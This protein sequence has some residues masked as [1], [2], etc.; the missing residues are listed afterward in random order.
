M[1]LNE[2]LDR[3]AGFEAVPY[4]VVSLY[5]NTQ[6]NERGRDSFQ[7]FVRKELKARAQT[8]PAKSPERETLERDLERITRY[9]ETDVKP[10]ANGIAIF[11]CDAAGLFE[12]IQLDGPLEDHWLSIGDQPHLYPLARVASQFP[13]CAAVVANTN[14]AQILVVAN[15]RVVSRTP[16]E[17]E[18][19]RRNSQGGWAQARFQRHIENY[20]LHHI[21]DV[22]EALEKIVRK[23]GLDRIVIAGDAVVRPLL[24]E[25]LPKPLA[26]MV[27]DELSLS[28]D[29]A[30]GDII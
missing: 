17:G 13:R 25:Q 5:L 28:A 15:G 12:T 23:E 14:T 29:A 27:V 10:S 3:L 26:E 4:P 9:M 11:A 8:Y 7:T 22:V 30:E 18:K 24:R 6:P 16:V 2:Q 1:T 20:H 21:K 19:T